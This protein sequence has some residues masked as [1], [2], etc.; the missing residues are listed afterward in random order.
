MSTMSTFLTGPE[1]HVVGTGDFNGDG[2]D[3]IL[4]Q[5]DNGTVRDWLGQA[6]GSFVGNSTIVNI[7]TDWHASAPA[8]STAT[9]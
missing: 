4:W 2:L 8:T 6:D 1:W 9:A 5:N 7:V 3:D